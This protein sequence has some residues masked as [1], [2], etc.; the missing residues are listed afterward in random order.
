MREAMGSLHELLDNVSRSLGAVFLQIEWAEEEIEAARQAHDERDRGPLWSSFKLLRS[1]CE[2]MEHEHIYRAHCRELLNRVVRG[3]DTGPGTDAE[4][5]CVL[6]TSGLAA[7]LTHG[8]CCLYF[9]LFERATGDL[10]PNMRKEIDLD[11]YESIHG[12]QADEHE[13]WLRGKLTQEF[14]HL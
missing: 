7:P 3:Q 9:R 14:R 11:A 13:E 5:I 10:W 2:G 12:T 6:R 4:M 1:T 8:A